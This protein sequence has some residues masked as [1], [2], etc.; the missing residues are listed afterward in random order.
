MGQC[1]SI[2]STWTK[3]VPRTAGPVVTQPR[4][5]CLRPSSRE[6][7]AEESYEAESR[8]TGRVSLIR[9]VGWKPGAT[10][11]T[12]C[13]AVEDD[14]IFFRMAGARKQ[15]PSFGPGRR[16]GTSVV[17]AIARTLWRTAG[18]WPA[19]TIQEI[20]VGVSE[21]L[22]YDVPSSTVRSELYR[23]DDVFERVAPTEGR[24]HY[25][26]TAQARRKA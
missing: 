21:E 3:R 25:R 14:S 18:K 20:R 12:S 16:G 24:V 10:E 5:C 4:V 1:A 8:R 23:R 7:V 2:T 15:V 26:L 13:A 11:Y 22:G 17:D 19:L 9:R 6:N